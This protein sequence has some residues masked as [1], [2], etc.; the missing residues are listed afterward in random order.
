MDRTRDRNDQDEDSDR[1]SVD[2]DR[3]DSDHDRPSR[4]GHDVIEHDITTGT[5]TEFD[6]PDDPVDGG[7]VGD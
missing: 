7:T 4:G 1:N 3:D 6:F 5:T 2:R